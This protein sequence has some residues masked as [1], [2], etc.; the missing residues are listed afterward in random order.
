MSGPSFVDAFDAYAHAIACG[1]P[2]IVQA[3]RLADLTAAHRT[4]MNELA[5]LEGFIADEEGQQ[6]VAAIHARKATPA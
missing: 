5:T 2:S 6:L 1:A 4:R 3:D